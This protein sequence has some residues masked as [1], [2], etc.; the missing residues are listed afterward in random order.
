MSTRLARIRADLPTATYE[1][2]DVAWLVELV[3]KMK[4]FLAH[5]TTCEVR[6]LIPEAKVHR[7]GCTCGL[8]D[9]S[10]RLE[11]PDHGM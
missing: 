7:I 1:P 9:V 11:E 2:E 8:D 4:L 5:K 3:D 6:W 10:A